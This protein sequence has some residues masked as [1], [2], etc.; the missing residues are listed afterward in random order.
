M[1]TKDKPIGKS[2]IPISANVQ[3]QIIARD[4]RAFRRKE[5][6]LES[7]TLNKET[8]CK[9]SSRPNNSLQHR[10]TQ[11]KDSLGVANCGVLLGA[12]MDAPADAPAAVGE[13]R[14]NPPRH[15]ANTFPGVTIPTFSNLPNECVRHYFDDLIMTQDMLHWDDAQL[16]QATK[17]GLRGAAKAWYHSTYCADKDDFG[18]LKEAMLAQFQE[19][20]PEW[21]RIYTLPQLKQQERESP[22]DFAQRITSH[23][24]SLKANDSLVLGTFLHG[25]VDSIKSEVIRENPATF[26]EAVAIATRHNVLN[27]TA[28]KQNSMSS[29]QMAGS[30]MLETQ[31]AILQSQMLSMQTQFAQK[32]ES[33][34]SAVPGQM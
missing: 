24:G 18:A 30:S 28:L 31:L 14:A 23:L 32:L 27:N 3:N 6:K 12:N 2:R 16:L 9:S 10:S 34:A 20:E 29:A 11:L 13:Q 19:N 17:L 25:L 22:K 5:R 33:L 8:R 26:A 7:N 1:S 15:F 4:E 21:Q